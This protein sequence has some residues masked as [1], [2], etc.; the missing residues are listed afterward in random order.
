MPRF[1]EYGPA[2]AAIPVVASE[3]FLML[4]VERH[5]V[6]DSSACRGRRS[7][8]GEIINLEAGIEYLASRNVSIDLRF[9]YFNLS[10][11]F[12][13]ERRLTE[14]KYQYRGPKL[15]IIGRF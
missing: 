4:Y 3:Q 13:N 8:G 10:A 9:S 7:I 5:N 12:T 6:V 1:L 2:T 14:I 11:N 15:G